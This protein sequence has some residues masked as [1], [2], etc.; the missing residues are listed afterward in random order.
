[1]F[2]SD[3]L[4][5]MGIY[6]MSKIYTVG[7]DVDIID[8]L[9]DFLLKE[10]KGN[11]VDLSSVAVVFPGKRPQFY[12]RKAL[13]SRTEKAFF[14]PQIFSI[15]EF[16]QYLAEKPAQPRQEGGSC[17]PI[18][19][20]DSCFLIYK[21]IQNLKLSHLEWQKQLEFEY[22]FLWARRI[23]QFLEELDKEM[24]SEKQLLNLQENAQIGLPLPDYINQLLENINQMRKE[25]HR[26][27]EKD[28][29]TTTGFNYYKAAQSI[30]RISLTE[31]R[32]VYFAGFFA[33]NA[34]EKR[35]IKHLLG[36][37]LAVLFWQ[38]DADTWSIFEELERFF[39]FLPEKIELAVSCPQVRIYEGF[40]THSQM[41]AVRQ[42]LM[43]LKD[44]SDTCIVLPQAGA[45][46]PLL[47][48]ALPSNLTDYNISLGYPLRRTPIYALIDT[49]IQAQERKRLDGRF[50]TRDYLKVIMHP[51]IKNIGDDGF[52]PD[53]TRI[54]IHKIEESLLGIDKA[55][56]SGRKAFI[57]PEEIEENHLLF[58]ITAGLI[59]NSGIVQIEPAGLRDQLRVIHQKFLYAFDNC[60]TLLDFVQ[61]VEG[62]VYFVLEKSR[63]SSDV[64]AGEAISRIL[65]V[66]EELRESLLKDEPIK[67]AAFFS[68]FKLRLLFEKIPFT[69]TPVRG[70]QI[71][72]LLET[73]N[74]QFNNVLILDI[75][76]GILPR[77]D[78]GES[79][80]P[81]GVLSGLG[82]PHYHKR[83]EIIRYHFRRLTSSAK[84]V[85]LIYEASSGDRESRSRFI[86]EAIWQQEK[87]SGRLHD[88][89]EIRHIEFKAAVIKEKFCL[90][91]TPE[92]LR[93]LKKIIFSPTSL[94]TYLNC[95]AQ[96]YFRYCLGLKEKE[97]ILEEFEA[98]DIG[99]FLHSLLRDFYSLFLNKPVKLNDAA[100]KYLF[101]LKQKKLEEFFP[102]QTGER[103][104]L[105][106]IIDYKLNVFFNREAKRQERIKILY[107]EQQ[108]PIGLNRIS[109][110]TECG[111]VYLRGT[112][113]RVDERMLNGE[114]RIVIVDYKTGRYS[115]PKKS[116]SEGCLGSRQ[117][118]RSAL[119]SFQLPLY[120]YLVSE[121]GLISYP[122]LKASFYSLREMREEFLFGGVNFK[123]LL[124]VCMRAA[125]KIISEI[126]S[127]DF[128]FVRDDSNEQ[129]CS[130]C[131]FSA[132]CKR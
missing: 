66:L 18:S 107:L 69:G 9:A 109:I 92:V 29:L 110:D 35:I 105:S 82:L 19:L 104:L 86:E 65:V 79:L 102:Q 95:P 43:S 108:L 93:I 74:L 129:Y 72:G 61:A 121:S 53:M 97:Q 20:L 116:F 71:L 37:K 81:E 44:L 123:E 99:N 64:F 76:E 103:F 68:L 80:I 34:C 42:I 122:R 54:L 2:Y 101:E 106:R 3:C 52:T 1:M 75:N 118:I 30:D 51:F 124:E 45:L 22:F 90:R 17:H 78:K 46:M 100:Y 32:Q 48:Y 115:L 50:Y 85:F 12:L 41:E 23:F 128:N 127:S 132:L 59:R 13:A 25:F 111:S 57:A 73:R 47:Y 63:V 119:G 7:F 28:K 26:S 130:W 36:R 88:P 5:F 131:P 49:L 56:G 14:P 33:L 96:F 70:L 84:K 98:S 40:D 11:T 91:K 4:C 89:E 94:D 6:V 38:R 31:F 120:V 10:N 60:L 62:V 117:E 15:E 21:I 113:D 83:E 8:Y 39:A 87:A 58:Q 112:I 114:R 125:R 77:I 67:K 55:A 24:V 126:I 27:L 16:I